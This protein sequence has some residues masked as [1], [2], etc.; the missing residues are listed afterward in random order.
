[1]QQHDGGHEER[2]EE[3]VGD[4]RG[5]ADLGLGSGLRVGREIRV[6]V[7][8]RVG[9]RARVRT[10][11]RVLEIGRGRADREEEDEY[12]ELVQ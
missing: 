8:A 2:E 1:V 4:D 12:V 7:G 9:V 10:R 3:R 5:R 6:G 11:V